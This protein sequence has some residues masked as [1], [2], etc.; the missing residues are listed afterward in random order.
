VLALAGHL[1]LDLESPIA[2]ALL[3]APADPDKF[4]IGDL[5]P[6]GAWP[7]PSTMVLSL[8]DPWL[9]FAAGRRW[10][11]TQE[12]RLAREARPARASI[13]EWAFSV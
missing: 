11:G 3:V 9:G 5:L 6:A 7:V 2:A 13:L 10:V 1:A 4:S 8:T 12:Q